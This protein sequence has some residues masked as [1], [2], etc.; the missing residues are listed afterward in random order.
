MW[1]RSPDSPH[2]QG[3]RLVPWTSYYHT[4]PPS[5]QIPSSEKLTG[6]WKKQLHALRKPA[7][8][9]E[10]AL[11]SPYCL[12]QLSPP[13]SAPCLLLMYTPA[14]PLPAPTL[15]SHLQGCECLYFWFL[16]SFR[17]SRRFKL[18]I[19]LLGAKHNIF[20]EWIRGLN[21][22]NVLSKCGFAMQ[23]Y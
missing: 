2:V 6:I 18:L 12:P 5:T 20:W 11:I 8:S 4:H 3:F 19:H 23:A 1:P 17:T 9:P 14:S 16:V 22:G 13:Q 21:L 7:E 15:H 10:D